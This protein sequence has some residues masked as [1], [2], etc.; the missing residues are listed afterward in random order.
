MNTGGS[1]ERQRRL[2]Q[3]SQNP[4]TSIGRLRTSTVQS[5]ADDDADDDNVTT[6]DSDQLHQ[7]ADQNQQ[8]VVY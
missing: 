5:H 2:H 7:I 4:V 3:I 6:D 8:L 1:M